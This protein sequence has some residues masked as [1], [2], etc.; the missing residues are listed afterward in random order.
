MARDLPLLS[1]DEL[2]TALA[3]LP[4]WSRDGERIR[5][6][7]TCAGRARSELLTAVAD[8]EAA[9]DHHTVTSATEDRLTFEVWTHS[10]GGLTR[11]D[12]ELAQRID[13]A[14]TRIT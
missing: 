14:V 5:R 7:V 12:V 10:A 1:D 11:L 3:R 6:T 4:A 8:A 13:E 2:A 9:L